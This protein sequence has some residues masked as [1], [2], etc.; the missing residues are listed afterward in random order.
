MQLCRALIPMRMIAHEAQYLKPL[1]LTWAI[2]DM[3]A[4]GSWG[5]QG[6]CSP[7]DHQP[8]HAAL[9]HPAGARAVL[10]VPEQPP[11]HCCGR[12]A[13]LQVLRRHTMPLSWEN[14][15]LSGCSYVRARV[16]RLPVQAWLVTL[17]ACH[18]GVFGCHAALVLRRLQRICQREYRRDPRFIVASATIANPQEHIQQ[19]LGDGSCHPCLLQVQAQLPW[20]F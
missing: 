14:F 17:L 10:P 2:L 15:C 8:R 7:A 6:A 4:G 18:R 3:P 5:G 13:R 16:S 20:T 9:Q 1:T 11:L 12:R 19:L